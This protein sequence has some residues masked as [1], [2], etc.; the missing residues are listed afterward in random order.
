VATICVSPEIEALE[1]RVDALLS[2]YGN[3]S[4]THAFTFKPVSDEPVMSTIRSL[5]QDNAMNVRYTQLVRERDDLRTRLV[6]AEQTTLDAH[7]LNRAILAD[8]HSLKE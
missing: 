2:Y 8:E 3:T 6:R 1:R 4:N 5:Q 7:E